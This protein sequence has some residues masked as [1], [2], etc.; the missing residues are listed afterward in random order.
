MTSESWVSPLPTKR[1]HPPQSRVFVPG[2][3]LAMQP[4]LDESAREK[5]IEN[6]RRQQ[7]ENS[8][9]HC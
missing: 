6:L 1:H 9:E 8:T 3:P 2:S 4:P 5:L 7:A